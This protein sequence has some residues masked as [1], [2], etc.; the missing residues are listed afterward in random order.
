MRALLI[1]LALAA[2]AA[3]A[4]SPTAAEALAPLIGCWRGTFDG[5]A[6]V[7]DERCFERLG[8]HVV[9]THRV[10]PTTYAGETTYHDDGAGGIVFAY[11]SNDGGRS[12][13]AV[14]PQVGRLV[15]PPHMHRAA[16]GAELRLRATWVLEAPDR[17]VSMSEVEEGGAW[18]PFMRIVYERA[19][20]AP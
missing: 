15:F 5:N 7:H 13:G 12:N 16:D 19:D 20:R 11:A 14:E 2:C 18:R 10:L 4:R 6:E 9:D 1:A 3:P 8:A 17:F